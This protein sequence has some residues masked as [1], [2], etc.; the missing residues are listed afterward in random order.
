MICL[1]GDGS[2]IMHMGTLAV[3]ASLDCPNLR[4]VLF[5]NGAHESVGGQGTVALNMDMPGLARACGFRW[6]RSV[7]SLDE[8]AP[9]FEALLASP[10]RAFLEI[11]I[12]IGARPDLGRPTLGPREMKENLMAFFRSGRTSD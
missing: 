3:S 9:A 6:V 4:Y 1:D 7:D 8:V 12:G 10:E 2:L 5:N 11:K